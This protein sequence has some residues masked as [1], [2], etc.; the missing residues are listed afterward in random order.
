MSISP[1]HAKPA[2]PE[3]ETRR[4]R[5]VVVIAIIG[6]A[7]TLLAY[8]ISPGVRHAV[9]S[10]KNSVSKVLDHDTKEHAKKGAPASTTSTS[11]GTAAPGLIITIPAG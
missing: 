4:A 11:G 2:S 6:I 7:A 9:H 3:T 8:A 1:F 10:V 5:L